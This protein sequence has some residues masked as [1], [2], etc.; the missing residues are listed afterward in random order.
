MSPPLTSL[1]SDNLSDIH[2][3][4]L[5]L[6]ARDD[7]GIFC[8]ESHREQSHG[9]KTELESCKWWGRKKI[10]TLT[11]TTAAVEFSDL[12][13]EEERRNVK[14]GGLRAS[15]ASKPCFIFRCSRIYLYLT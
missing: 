5:E 15:G 11:V 14:W 9:S 1:V 7:K 4:L 2:K 8:A 13:F 10:K 3:S 12:V 6:E